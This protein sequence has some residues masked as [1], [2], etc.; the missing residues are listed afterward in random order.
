M[1]R[2]AQVLLCLMFAATTFAQGFGLPP[3]KW[4]KIPK[5][6]QKLELT[7]AQQNQLDDVFR[8]A[9]P[10]LIDLK[11]ELEKATISLR[12]A[13]DQSAIDR[14]EVKRAVA[15]VND[16]RADLFEAE[17]MLLVD[18]RAVLS[19]TQ[20][21]ELRRALDERRGPMHDRRRPGGP[22]PGSF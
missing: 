20:W 10:S 11:A 12:G 15:R 13:V 22:P 1:K 17:L 3:G 9:A 4:W 19:E 8:T 18:M 6:V 16:A 21:N 7:Q 5:V 14:T 2:V